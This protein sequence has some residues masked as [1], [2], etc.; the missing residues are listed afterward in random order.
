MILEALLFVISGAVGIA[1]G[2]VNVVVPDDWLR[3]LRTALHGTGTPLVKA[4]TYWLHPQVITALSVTFEIIVALYFTRLGIRAIRGL[5]R[6]W[7][8]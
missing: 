2:A 6:F 3:I 7:G 8:P 4:A 1:E 5:R